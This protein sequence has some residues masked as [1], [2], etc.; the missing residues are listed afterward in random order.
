MSESRTLIEQ[1]QLCTCVRVSIL[2]VFY[3]LKV[4]VAGRL[5]SAK[6]SPSPNGGDGSLDTVLQTLRAEIC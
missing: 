3:G 5:S 1:C 6:S 2:Y 4:P